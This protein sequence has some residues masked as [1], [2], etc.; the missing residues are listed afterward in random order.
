VGA[1]MASLFLQNVPAVG[2]SGA[3]FGLLGALLSE[4]VWNWKY[5]TKKVL[6]FS[7]H[8]CFSLFCVI[9]F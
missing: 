7:R 8:S 5:H 4:L 2:S 1:L 6:S 3:L 9:D